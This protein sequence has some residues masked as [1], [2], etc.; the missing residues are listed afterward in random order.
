MIDD[1][2]STGG[3]T[4]VSFTAGLLGFGLPHATSPSASATWKRTHFRTAR[5]YPRPFVWTIFGHM[6]A[7]PEIEAVLAP[8]ERARGFPRAAFVDPEVFAFEQR[9]IFDRA[10]ICVGR[11]EEISLPGQWIRAEIGAEPVLV[12]R[13]PDLRVRAFFDVCRHRGASVVGR[14]SCG[15][16]AKF[17]CPYHG[18]TY[19]LDGRSPSKFTTLTS[20]R[21]E[22]WN[23]FVFVSAG[24]EAADMGP[25]PPWLSAL[26]PLKLG[27]RKEWTTD[28]NW[29]LCVEN[30]Q[31]SHH[32]PRVHRALEALTPM[33]EAY[34][35]SEGTRW[36]GGTMEI[37]DAET[38]SRTGSL[39]GRPLIGPPR[40]V[41]DAHLFPLLLTSLQP[42]YFLMY[43]LSPRAPNR[44]HITFDVGV[45]PAANPDAPAV[46]ELWDQ[47]NAEDRAIIEDQQRN[48]RSRAF[49][50]ACYEAVEEGMH[51]FDR[52]VASAYLEELAR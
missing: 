28:A 3:A 30:F 22:L 47:I 50:P 14:R 27:R 41:H 24:A 51:A 21:A 4:F 18:W 52:L 20:V 23:G 5:L 34:T 1:G 37:V 7:R 33:R 45:H 9:A 35:W 38:V 26:G 25:P 48:A 43:R 8:L 46:Y 10:W 15:R 42:D 40:M 6:L 2:C 11:E 29:K 13:G 31:E 44:T 19:E 12:A 36:L 32:F 49:P 17:E 16:T 39:D